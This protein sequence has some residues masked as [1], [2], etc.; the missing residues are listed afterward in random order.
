MAALTKRCDR[1]CVDV[2]TYV[3]K[4][5]IGRR[6]ILAISDAQIRATEGRIKDMNK[7]KGEN[8]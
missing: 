4:K 1:Q 6:D 3:K 7:E 8:E 5:K 2:H